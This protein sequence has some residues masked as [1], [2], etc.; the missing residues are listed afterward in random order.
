MNEIFFKLTSIP[1]GSGVRD[2]YLSCIRHAPGVLEGSGRQWLS[3]VRITL[4]TDEWSRPRASFLSSQLLCCGNHV[5]IFCVSSYNS[6]SAARLQIPHLGK[7]APPEVGEQ[8]DFCLG[9]WL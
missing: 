8:N 2:L 6:L 9:V 7:Q 1:S 3:D 4:K 5:F